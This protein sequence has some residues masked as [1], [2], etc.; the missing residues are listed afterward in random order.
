MFRRALCSRLVPIQLCGPREVLLGGRRGWRVLGGSILL[1]ERL[2]PAGSQGSRAAPC[3][4]GVLPL[5]DRGG[6]HHGRGSV[7]GFT[8]SSGTV[9]GTWS[10]PMGW[11]AGENL[12]FRLMSSGRNGGGERQAKRSASAGRREPPAA[13]GSDCHRL[14]LLTVPTPTVPA[15]LQG[16]TLGGTAS[17]GEDRGPCPASPP[18]SVCRGVE[19]RG[20]RPLRSLTSPRGHHP[21]AV[22]RR[23]RAPFWQHLAPSPPRTARQAWA[24]GWGL[25]GASPSP[26]H[27][28]WSLTGVIPWAI[29]A[30]CV[31]LRTWLC[32]PRPPEAPRSHLKHAGPGLAP[33]AWGADSAFACVCLCASLLL[34][35]A[36]IP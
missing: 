18:C 34:L 32:P 20:S 9:V 17:W 11:S 33:G 3:S 6:F 26:L 8:P 19:P 23:G 16:D 22:A 2:H 28:G 30:C 35:D 14:S 12:L 4:L 36:L 7:G 24:G 15:A 29:Q 13:P 10:C 25:P 21:A 1:P 5:R 31:L 27:P